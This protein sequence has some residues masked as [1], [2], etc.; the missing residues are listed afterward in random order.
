VTGNFLIIGATLAL[1]IMLLG[2]ISGAAV[3][4]A[5]CVALMMTGTLNSHDVLPYILAEI[6]GAILAVEVSK[7]IKRR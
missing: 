2:P 3:N 5:V 4:P 1:I 7:L 6:A